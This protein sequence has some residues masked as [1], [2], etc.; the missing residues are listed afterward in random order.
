MKK[1]LKATYNNYQFKIKIEFI[2]IAG[3]KTKVVLPAILLH[4]RIFIVHCGK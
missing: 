1:W 2:D 4:E 3:K